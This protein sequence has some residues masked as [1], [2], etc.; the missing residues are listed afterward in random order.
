ML[1]IHIPFCDY[2]CGY[3]SF[4][5]FVDK[6]SV[7]EYFTALN[8][9]LKT[10]L[11]NLESLRSIYIGGGTP[12]SVDPKHYEKIFTTL[13]HH[14]KDVTEITVEAN[15]KSGNYSWF[16]E[17]RNFGVNRLSLGVQSFNGE[18]L[19]LLTRVHSE[20]EAKNSF[21]DGRKAGFENISIDLIYDTALDSEKILQEELLGI[22]DLSPE[23][24]SAY[25]LI[26]EEDS[27]FS[28]KYEKKKDSETLQKL[29][30]GEF[31]KLLPQYEISNFGKKSVH[32]SGYWEYKEYLGV[33]AGAVGRVKS[34]RTYPNKDLKSYIK[35]PLFKEIE[36]L[37]KEDIKCEKIFLG[38]RSD[39]GFEISIL[40]EKE[41]SRVKI[42]DQE[43]KIKIKDSKVYNND[44]FIA[45][46][47]ALFIM[48]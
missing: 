20:K 46:E 41:K 19:N 1:Y 10:D 32:N 26:I 8:R 34:S 7:E 31:N 23:H 17:M 25:S 47:L 29:Y 18:K 40:T 27:S 14:L 11:E 33:G 38:L 24:L 28:G 5:S 44:Y 48:D 9:Q 16:K 21:F 35:D 3:C 30:V 45:D 39:A 36:T 2:K 13:Q 42:L 43:K 12:S 22:K 37:N 15:P 4:N 6:G